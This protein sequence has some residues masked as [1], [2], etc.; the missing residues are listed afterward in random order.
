ME[1]ERA[2]VQQTLFFQRLAA[3]QQL[4]IINTDDVVRANILADDIGEMP[5]ELPIS[6][7]VLRREMRLLRVIM[8]H[9]PQAIVIVAL[10]VEVKLLGR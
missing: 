8:E 5:V 3:G 1:E 4:V 7:V 9:W 10:I 6:A 2:G